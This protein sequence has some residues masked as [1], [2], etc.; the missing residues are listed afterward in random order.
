MHRHG[1]RG[2]VRKSRGL[3]GARPRGSMTCGLWIWANARGQRQREASVASF[4]GKRSARARASGSRC[5]EGPSSTTTPLATAPT[6]EM[7]PSSSAR[8]TGS[9]VTRTT[10]PLAGPSTWN[11]KCAPGPETIRLQSRASTSRSASGGTFAAFG[12]SAAARLRVAPFA[13]T[14]ANGAGISGDRCNRPE[15]TASFTA[16]ATEIDDGC[17]TETPTASAR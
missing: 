2:C 10:S 1:V 15:S 12:A 14:N 4:P 9:P 13:H 16:I 11:S 6:Q 17:A 7:R 8:N 5:A 3:A